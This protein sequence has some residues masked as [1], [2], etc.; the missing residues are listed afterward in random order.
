MDV[1]FVEF[2]KLYEED[3]RPKLI[4]TNNKRVFR[5]ISQDNPTNK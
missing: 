4:V 1:I 5:G 2:C 3:I